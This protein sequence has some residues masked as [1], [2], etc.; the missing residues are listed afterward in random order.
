[1]GEHYLSSLISG[2][3]G[4]ELAGTFAGRSSRAVAF[5]GITMASEAVQQETLFR[6][7]QVIQNAFREVTTPLIDQKRTREQLEAP[8]TASGPR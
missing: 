4:L 7:Q 3:P 1:M 8:E 6:Y 5:T 2:L